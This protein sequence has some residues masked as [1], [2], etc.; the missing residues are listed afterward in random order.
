MQ[1][2]QPMLWEIENT[3]CRLLGS[4]HFLPNNTALPN[5]VT[6]S[7]CG[8]KKIVFEGDFRNIP[9][10]Q[11]GID[12]NC[13]HLEQAGALEIYQRAKTL[14]ATVGYVWAFG[15]SGS[16]VYINGPY[17]FFQGH[18]F[19]DTG[20]VPLDKIFGN[21]P[22]PQIDASKPKDPAAPK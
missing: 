1:G 4:A 19:N 17:K 9:F 20:S 3:N 11:V 21:V 13:K 22:L 18:H 6:A 14:I 10:L 12:N 15:V 16:G 5:W 2:W 8:I 7:L